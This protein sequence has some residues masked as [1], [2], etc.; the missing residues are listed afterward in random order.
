MVTFKSTSTRLENSKET[1]NCLTR[2]AVAIIR[3]YLS[4][5]QLIL[6]I[7]FINRFMDKSK[8]LF[9]CANTI[10][11]NIYIENENWKQLLIFHVKEWS[12]TLF[13]FSRW[14]EHKNINMVVCSTHEK[15]PWTL[16]MFSWWTQLHKYDHSQCTWHLIVKQFAK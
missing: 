14:K 12:W 13:M 6:R 15:Q 10:W 8:V 5:H 11:K 9:L 4:I 3:I 7:C 1:I 16:F 2:K